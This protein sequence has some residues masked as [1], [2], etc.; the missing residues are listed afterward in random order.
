MDKKII[1]AY[2]FLVSV[3]LFIFCA[4]CGETVRGMS[5]DAHRVGRGAKTMLI[6]DE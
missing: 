3:F 1:G 5:K 2:F 4:G 6:A